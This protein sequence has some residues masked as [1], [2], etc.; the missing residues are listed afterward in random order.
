MAPD[1]S[2][3]GISVHT[4]SYSELVV[5]ELIGEGGFAK[6]YKGLQQG[7]VV[8]IKKLTVPSTVSRSGVVTQPDNHRRDMFSEFRREAWLMSGLE[9]PNLVILKGLCLEP[10]CIVMEFMNA[11]TLHALIHCK[12]ITDAFPLSLILRIALD[13]AKGMEFLHGITPP[14]VHRDL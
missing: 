10:F 14:I 7:E 5:S 11:G 13:V 9:H 6:V 12:T 3:C 1:I 8:A 2:M 4:L